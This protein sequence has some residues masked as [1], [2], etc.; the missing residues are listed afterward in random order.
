M[1]QSINDDVAKSLLN[2]I[3]VLPETETF[4]LFDFVNIDEPSLSKLIAEFLNPKGSHNLGDI[5]LKSFLGSVNVDYSS[6]EVDNWEI[7]AEKSYIDILIKKGSECIIIIENKAFGAQD[8]PGQLFRYFQEKIYKPVQDDPRN[9]DSQILEIIKNHW[10]GK[11]DNKSRY[12]IIY[13][14]PNS[15]KQPSDQS[16][17]APEMYQNKIKGFD[18]IPTDLSIEV[19][20]VSNLL[21]DVFYKALEDSEKREEY[22]IQVIYQLNLYFD[23]LNKR[24]NKIME[25]FKT[26]D[27]YA[28]GIQLKK[29]LN[30]IQVRWKENFDKEFLEILVKNDYDDWKFSGTKWGYVWTLKDYE[31]CITIWL[32]DFKY[33]SIYT[34]TQDL[35]DKVKEDSVGKSLLNVFM[36]FGEESS[37]RSGDYGYLKTVDIK[38]K[39]IENRIDESAFESYEMTLWYCNFDR[40]RLL[41]AY[42]TIFDKLLRS[43]T[44]FFKLMKQVHDRINN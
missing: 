31:K 3:S 6:E 29:D 13:L 34:N 39:L 32:E 22:F 15:W 2:D 19:R 10:I 28:A 42:K 26:K 14:S 18:E 33:L 16:R 40:E 37:F 25:I 9:N 7:I 41:E 5:F 12:G 21:Y 11:K 36:G 44:D 43:D 24:E 8:Q 30:N 17:K 35:F 1:S 20:Y 4:N 23:G 27:S 38:N